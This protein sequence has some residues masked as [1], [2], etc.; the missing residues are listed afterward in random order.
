MGEFIFGVKLRL[1]LSL[2]L[3][4]LEN[5]LAL[6]GTLNFE[7]TEVNDGS[8]MAD[9]LVQLAPDFFTVTWRARIIN[10]TGGNWK[11]KVS[12]DCQCQLFHEKEGLV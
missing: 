8:A 6:G 5:C 2:I 1:S 3:G 7:P 12:L 4:Q 11:L 9:C 10:E